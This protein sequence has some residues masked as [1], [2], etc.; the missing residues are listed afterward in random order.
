MSEQRIDWFRI[1]T[2]L[3]RSGLSLEQIG[4][5]VGRSKTQVIAYKS[6]PGTEPR[7]GVG[8]ALLELWQQRCGDRLSAAPTLEN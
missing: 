2:D 6:I 7:F 5:H 8:V 1:I 3:E 4:D